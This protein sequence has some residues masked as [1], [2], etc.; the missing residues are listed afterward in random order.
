MQAARQ[1]RDERRRHRRFRVRHV[2]DHQ[3]QIL[4]ILT[5]DFRQ[6]FRPANGQIAF[7]SARRDSHRNPAQVLDQRQAQHDRNRPQLTQAQG[8]HGLIG[9]D[10]AAQAVRVDASIAMR[11]GFQRDVV[12]PRQAAGNALGQAGQFTAVAF[13]QVA[14]GGADLLFDQIQIV[15]QPFGGRGDAVLGDDRPSQLAAGLDQHHLVGIQSRQQ[16]VCPPSRRDAVRIRQSCAV[17][18]HLVGA[19]QLGAQRRFFR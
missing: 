13:R 1:F 5:R 10:E 7:L 19:E 15:E 11:D 3:N 8:R 18:R 4:R 2:G 9:G 16:L 12:Y 17:L 6:R 14:A